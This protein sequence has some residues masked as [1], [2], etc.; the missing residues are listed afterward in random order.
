ML[1]NL[2][3]APA[4]YFSYSSAFSRGVLPCQVRAMTGLP[5]LDDSAVSPRSSAP[6]LP[7]AYP[8]PSPTTATVSSIPA[9]FA[10]MWSASSMSTGSVAAENWPAT[11]V[12]D[13]FR[14][15]TD[16]D[17]VGAAPEGRAGAGGRRGHLTRGSRTPGRR[18]ELT[19]GQF[20]TTRGFLHLAAHQEWMA[21]GEHAACGRARTLNIG[22][23]TRE[24]HETCAALVALRRLRRR[25]PPG[26]S[27]GQCGGGDLRPAG[28]PPLARAAPTLARGRQRARLGP[29]RARPPHLSGAGLRLQRP[30]GA[31]HAPARSGAGPSQLALRARR[32]GARAAEVHARDR[33]E[34]VQVRT[35]VLRVQERG[36]RAQGRAR[37]DRA[38]PLRHPR[39]VGPGRGPRGRRATR[40]GARLDRARA[41]RP[42][43][44][45]AAA[46]RADPAGGPGPAPR[47][48]GRGR[49]GLTTGS[50]RRSGAPLLDEE[51]VHVVGVLLLLGQDR[52][53]HVA[54][55]RV[56]VGEV[57]DHGPVGLDRDPLSDEVLL[58][59]AAQVVP[60]RVLGG[61]AR[62]Q[63]V[64][65][66][67]RLPAQLVDALAD[68][69]GVLLLLAGMGSELPLH[70]L[71]MDPLRGDG[72]ELVPQHADQLGRQ[73]VVEELEG[74]RDVSFVVAGDGA[75]VHVLP[76]PPA[77]LLHVHDERLCLG[78]DP[79]PPANAWV[80]KWISISTGRAQELGTAR[81]AGRRAG[82]ARSPERRWHIARPSSCKPAWRWGSARGMR[83]GRS[84]SRWR[85][86]CGGASKSAAS[87]PRSRPSRLRAISASRWPRWKMSGSS[88]SPGTAP[89]RSTPRSTS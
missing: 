25:A 64:G 85:T 19:R 12:S 81:R 41:A 33:S 28:D 61:G 46:L 2:V 51:V 45:P 17:G 30:G 44:G 63:A 52:L 3:M 1:G 18:A 88:T 14:A 70:R 65:V 7:P 74:G 11:A 42:A 26:G 49:P 72:V 10:F 55:G 66:E 71:A 20:R 43:L 9:S 69:V 77:Q 87:P 4:R 76:C 21:Q 40:A 50:R 59:H 5:G 89:T 82:R 56:V 75:F 37:E 31:A 73:R 60:L 27:P 8:R 54:G 68:L 13:R 15:E 86:A 38:A 83:R 34:E 24:C 80:T 39:A 48:R 67:V 84:W 47:D 58:D 79:L 16:M 6:W 23:I 57:P 35:V 29:A 53:Q 78:H 36:R 22:A 32:F 62:E